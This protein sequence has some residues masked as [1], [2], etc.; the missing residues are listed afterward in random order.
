MWD[1]IEAHARYQFDARK[2]AHVGFTIRPVDIYKD[3]C[4]M[5]GLSGDWPGW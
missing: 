3:L 1:G 4:K 5:T 2:S